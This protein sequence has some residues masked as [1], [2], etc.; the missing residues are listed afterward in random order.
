MLAVQMVG[1]KMKDESGTFCT[2][3]RSDKTEKQIGSQKNERT[4]LICLP[5]RVKKQTKQSRPFVFWENL[6]A[7]ICFWN[8]LTFRTERLN[9]VWP[10]KSRVTLEVPKANNTIQRKFIH[11]FILC[12]V[13]VCV[14]EGGNKERIN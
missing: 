8:Y 7:P 13:C 6:C 11:S 2:N 5:W 14:N 3:K 12:Y 4:N 9:Y 10:N 1:L